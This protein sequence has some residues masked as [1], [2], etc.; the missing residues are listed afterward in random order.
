MPARQ[1]VNVELTHP[2]KSTYR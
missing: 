1:S 2:L